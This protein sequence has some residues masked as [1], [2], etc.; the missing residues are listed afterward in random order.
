MGPVKF[1]SNIFGSVSS[2]VIT[3]LKAVETTAEVVNVWADTAKVASELTSTQM[4]DEIRYEN[5]LKAEELKALL[6]QDA[7][8]VK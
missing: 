6:A 8:T 1:F 7:P 4:L 2:V 3:T 5:A